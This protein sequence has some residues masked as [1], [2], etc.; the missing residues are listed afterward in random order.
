MKFGRNS[1]NRAR[2]AQVA[3]GAWWIG[4]R[5][6]PPPQG[7]S[8]QL[9]EFLAQSPVPALQ[10]SVK[11]M[12]DVKVHIALADREKATLAEE[13]ARQE[14][15][16]I[17]EDNIAGV[18]V[19]RVTPPEIASEHA[20]HLFV[21]VHGGG[22]IVGAGLAGMAEAVRIAAFLRLPV[23]S[24]DYRMAPDHP[25]PAAMDDVIAVWREL[26]KERPAKKTAL[27]GTSAGATL[28]LVATLK[29]KELGLALPA[30][31]FVGTPAADLAKRG[32]MRFINDGI[33]HILVNWNKV[34]YPIALYV[35]DKNYDDPYIS[36]IFGDF[37]GFPPT[38]LIS[39]TRDL[40]LSDTVRTHRKLRQAGVIADLHVYEGVAHADYASMDGSPEQ[41]EH[42]AELNA[43]LLRHFD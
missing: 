17:T 19:S 21:H 2:E 32:D 1:S 38:Y 22:F 35:G 13:F 26:I 7:A 6:L 37:A 10:T 11:T 30:A 14:D 36:P 18:R 24:I 25:A 34:E 29:M 42:H 31:L 40:M 12:K 5:V 27:G 20:D 39:G 41:R 28:T 33:D 43:F 3:E 15:I 16:T 9:R 8:N 4:P 23:L